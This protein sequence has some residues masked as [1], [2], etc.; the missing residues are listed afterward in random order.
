MEK[1]IESESTYIAIIVNNVTSC[2]YILVRYISYPSPKPST[3][4]LSILKLRID[5]VTHAKSLWKK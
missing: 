4:E 1:D 2:S 5:N 3:L